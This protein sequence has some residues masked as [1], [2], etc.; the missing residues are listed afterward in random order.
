MPRAPKSCGRFGCDELVVGRTYCA[1]HEAERQREHRSPSSRAHD[2]HNERRRRAAVVAA[3]V[4]IN[5]WVCPGWQ[6]DPHASSDLTAAHVLAV[7]H[8]GGDGPLTVL[9][10]RCNSQ[11]GTRAG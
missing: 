2:N 10:R 4:R 5:G 8:G 3:W 1:E 6:R 7:A 9:C 11:Q